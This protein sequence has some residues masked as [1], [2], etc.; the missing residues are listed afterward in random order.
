[1]VHFAGKDLYLNTKSYLLGSSDGETIE[2]LARGTHKF[3]F[4]F[5]LPSELPAS[6]ETSHGHIN[7]HIETGLDSPWGFDEKFKTEFTVVRCDDLNLSPE[8]VLQ[9]ES[10]E[11]KN[12]CRLFCKSKPLVMT[13]SLPQTGYVPGETIKVSIKYVNHSQVDVHSTRIDLLRII[14]LNR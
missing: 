11:I 14:C 6:F 13:V 3:E 10:E 8:L 4:S 5:Q 2:T 1:M 12:F 7:Y 9:T